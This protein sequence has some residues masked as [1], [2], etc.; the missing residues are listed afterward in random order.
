[1]NERIRII[2]LIMVFVQALH[3]IEEYF[4]RLWEVLPP[5]K[6]LSSLVFE[7][8]EKGFLIINIG[9]FIFGLS[10]YFFIINRNNFFGS[11]VIWFW[12]VIEMINGVGH[13]LWAL[14]ERAYVPGVAT[15]PFLLILAVYLSYLF[16]YNDSK[17]LKNN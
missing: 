10:S 3:S 4:G 11:T 8:L 6:F 15:A 17:H 9:L 5:A 1:M 7:N 2:F 16:V 14:I 12:I 13:P